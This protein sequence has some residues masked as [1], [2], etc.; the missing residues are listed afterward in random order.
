MWF[1]CVFSLI[2]KLSLGSCAS[3]VK[4]DAVIEYLLLA[5]M[6]GEHPFILIL[7]NGRLGPSGFLSLYGDTGVCAA[8]KFTSLPPHFCPIPRACWSQ[9]RT[10]TSLY[11]SGH[12][13]C[14]C[15]HRPTS[16]LEYQARTYTPSDAPKSTMSRYT[17]RKSEPHVNYRW[18]CIPTEGLTSNRCNACTCWL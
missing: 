17:S 6:A 16:S 8:E 18:L 2:L 7:L 5:V 4:G 14:S 15:V 1:S 13:M 10:A 9:L 12:R 3:L 11:I